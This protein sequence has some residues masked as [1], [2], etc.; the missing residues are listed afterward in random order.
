MPVE[1]ATY[2]LQAH[3]FGDSY[4]ARVDRR[5]FLII[6]N[7]LA[8]ISDLIGDGRING[9]EVTVSDLPSLEFN[10]SAGMGI[11]DR[12]VT[13]TLNDQKLILSDNQTSYIYMRRRLD[14]IAGSSGFSNLSSVVVSDSTAPAVPTSLSTTAITFQSIGLDWD[15]NTEADLSHYVIE[16]S[17]D[18]IVWADLDTSTTSSFTDSTVAENTIYY[19]R[20]RAVDFSGNDSASSSS[21]MVMTVGNLSVPLDPFRVEVISHNGGGEVY[22]FEPSVSSILDRYEIHVQEMDESNNSVGSNVVHTVTTDRTY[23]ILDDLQNS[24]RYM[25]TAFSVSSNGVFSDG[26]SRFIT[27]RINTL[28]PE[29]EDATISYSQGVNDDANIVMEI[30]WTP[31][32]DAYDVPPVSYIIDLL[33]DELLRTESFEVDGLSTDISVLDFVNGTSRGLAASTK[34]TVRIRGVDEEGNI[35]VGVILNTKSPNFNPPSPISSPVAEQRSD[36]SILASWNNSPSGF[37]SNNLITVTRVDNET[38]AETIIVQDSDIGAATTYT[39]SASLFSENSTFTFEVSVVDTFGNE[40]DITEFSVVS[41][42]PSDFE[43]P[44]GPGD[45]SITSGDG[46]VT[47]KWGLQDESLTRSYNIYRADFSLLISASAFSLIDTVPN[48]VGKYQDFSVD[49]DSTYMFLITTIDIFNQESLNP[50]EDQFFSSLLLV[51]RPRDSGTFV[52]PEN[53]S[54]TQVGLDAALSW[55]LTAGVFDGYEIFR[56]IGNRYEFKSVANVSASATTFT[57]TDSM[58]VDATEYFYLIRKI[59]NS[60]DLFL[61]TSTI[62]PSNSTV[63]AKV[64]ISAGVPTIDETVA[65]ELEDLEDPIRDEAQR[66][67]AAH[68]HTLDDDGTDRRIDLSSNVVVED[69]TTADFQKY[70][71]EED[72]D[73]ASAFVVKMEGT[74]NEDFFKTVENDGAIDAVTGEA[75]VHTNRAAIEQLNRGISPFLFTVKTVDKRLT[76]ETKIFSTDPDDLVPFLDEPVISVTMIGVTEVEGELKESRVGELNATQITTGFVDER[77]IPNLDHDGRFNLSLTPTTIETVSVDGLTYEFDTSAR[78]P[79]N[80]ASVTFYDILQ[81]DG[82]TLIGATNRGIATSDDF[83]LTWVDKFT[84]ASASNRVFRSDALDRTFVLSNGRIHSSKGDLSS[85]SS[86]PGIESAKVIR[87]IIEDPAGNAYVSTDIGVFKLVID[88]FPTLRLWQQTPLFGA[89]STEAYAM[90]YDTEESRIIVSNEFGIL[91]STNSGASWSLTSELP[92]QDKIFAFAQA[93]ERIFALGNR[94]IFRK[95]TG[96]DF[97]IV[98]ELDGRLARKMV[99]YKD[100]LYVT[101]DLGT[102]VSDIGDDIY[103]D[104]TLTMLQAFPEVN[105]NGNIIPATSLNV[106]DGFL[107][108][109]IDNRLYFT[110]TDMLSL[111]FESINGVSPSVFVDGVLQTVGVRYLSKSSIHSISFDDVQ[112]IGSTVTV[113]PDYVEY[114][115]DQGG[116]AV[117]KYDARIVLRQNGT[118]L[119]DTKDTSTGF[120]LDVSIFTGFDFPTITESNSYPSGA[121]FWKARAED[122]IAVLSAEVAAA[123][124]AA[125]VALEAASVDPLSASLLNASNASV[126]PPTFP[127]EVTSAYFNIERFLSQMLPSGRVTIDS[128]TLVETEITAPVISVEISNGITVDVTNGLVVFGESRSKFDV[129]EADIIGSTIKNIGDVDSYECGVHRGIEDALDDVNSGLPANLARVVHSN[130][131]KF[132][133]HNEKRYPGQDESCGLPYQAKYIV[134]RDQAWY[135]VLNSTIDYSPELVKEDVSLSLP[136][137]SAVVYSETLDR[138]FVGGRGGLLSFG[139]TDLDIDEV[140]V[141]ELGGEE[142]DVRGLEIRDGIL[143]VLTLRNL[144]KSEDLGSTWTRVD[145]GGLPNELHSIGIVSNRFVIGGSDGVYFKAFDQDTWTKALDT[146]NPVELITDPDFIFVLAD[147]QLYFSS[148][149]ANFVSTGKGFSETINSIAKYK[150]LTFAGTNEG[151]KTDDGT[152]YTAN[153][154]LSLVNIFNDVEVS[155]AI[156]VNGVAGDSDKAIAGIS[157]G[158]YALLNGNI[159]TTVQTPLEAIQKIMLVGGNPWLFGYDLL[160]IYDDPVNGTGSPISEFPIRLSSGAPL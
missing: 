25:V 58:L 90:L 142:P 73:G 31:P 33:E 131:V 52:P 152:F 101:T 124:E 54:V 21:I 32:M 95:S 62:P 158:R 147:S 46:F 138:V 159:W 1:T 27:P 157:D 117:Q 148:D 75:I 132:G 12:F 112:S 49:N 51:G 97:T 82:N 55:D 156:V 151:L 84:T 144:F 71:T 59:R 154:A 114:Q 57:D 26:V 28:P 134:P 9:W 17:L 77:Q 74:V 60:A 53:L 139:A 126:Q 79:L 89:R 106:V 42:N 145:R 45:Q 11:I 48:N 140:T 72:L 86:M 63:L 120:P 13:R 149:G 127:D 102:L 34:Y 99:I 128:T 107:F 4:S 141:P 119:I 93:N 70:F 2:G 92:E 115:I 67:I 105:Q 143:Y 137:A 10:I 150:S 20:L 125:A 40:S 136:Y 135:D 76:F 16:R 155:E 41:L 18:N 37:F 3:T 110:N 153:A 5:R 68:K 39:V 23:L 30:S 122:A 118:L 85:W 65:I 47:L 80:T 78:T 88:N 123:E 94:R 29:I 111:Q 96:G 24:V 129:L 7:Q 69:W 130:V 50:V 87:D 38:L 66:Q 108:L 44:D 98:A 35:S 81:D 103:G 8:F 14:V 15:D 6:D 61:T 36:K 19:Y 146:T 91:E 22:W 100:R 113:A 64:S 56:S 104:A 160:M 116:W 133:I 121:N 109:G 83:G 43:R